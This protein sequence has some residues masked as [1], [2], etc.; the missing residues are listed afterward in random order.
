M[1]IDPCIVVNGVEDLFS[2][3]LY[4]FEHR[5]KLSTASMSIMCKLKWRGVDLELV[6]IVRRKVP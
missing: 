1:D 6:G 2:E 4:I 5:I 3:K